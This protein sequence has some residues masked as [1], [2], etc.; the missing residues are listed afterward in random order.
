MFERGDRVRITRGFGDDN[1]EL[2]IGGVGTVV[3]AFDER[4]SRGW[5]E[6][7]REVVIKLDEGVQLVEDSPKVNE[8]FSWPIDDLEAL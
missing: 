5:P 7:F 2:L 3:V 8:V 4:V 1:D 6:K